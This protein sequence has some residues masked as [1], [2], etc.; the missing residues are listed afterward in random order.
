MAAVRISM[1]TD[2]AE[3]MTGEGIARRSFQTRGAGTD[4]LFSLV[5]DGVNTGAAVVTLVMARETL[6]KFAD[7]LWA[8]FRRSEE[9]VL[10]VTIAA[11]GLREQV[12][13]HRDD[14]AA[15]DKILDLL[16]AAL[17]PDGN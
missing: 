2:L 1:P 6:V 15:V 9:D 4:A 17:H 10:T 16:I 11:P 8:W 12:K 14:R 3:T 7:R 5:I 13:V